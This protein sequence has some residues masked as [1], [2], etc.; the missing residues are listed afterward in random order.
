MRNIS[1]D[2]GQLVAKRSS[3]DVEIVDADQLS[4]TL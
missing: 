1:R 2:E 4:P 3:G